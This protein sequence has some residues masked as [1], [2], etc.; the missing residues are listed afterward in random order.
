MSNTKI[1]FTKEELEEGIWE[2]TSETMLC[3]HC[4]EH[5]APLYEIENGKIGDFYGSNCCG[6]RHYFYGA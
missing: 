5:A 3:S 1:V 2:D 6:S 4:Q